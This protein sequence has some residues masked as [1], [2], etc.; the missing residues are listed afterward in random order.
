MAKIKKSKKKFQKTL[1]YLKT[2][3]RVLFLTTSNRWEGEKEKP[4]STQLAYEF[5]S[6]LPKKKV[7]ILEVPK[8]KIFPCEGNVS[9]SKGNRCGLREAVLNDK[10]KNPTGYH[11]CFAS[12]NNKDDEL[13][14]ISREIFRA[15]TV[16]FFASVRW[17]QANS[18]YQKLI[19]RLTWIENRHS[20]LDEKNVVAKIV[21]GFICVGQNWNGKKVVKT[22]KQVLKYFG[23]RVPK[24]LSW[25]WQYEK[26][27][28]DES[29]DAYKKGVVEFSKTF[30][31]R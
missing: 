7:K 5:A 1:A 22:Q 27:A 24:E 14:K 18:V 29:D 9:T 8:M 11:R 30:S 2:K 3:K 13:W 17:G 6:Q 4:K 23:F 12:L 31:L 10:K 21:A 19:E 25:N 28:D 20:T 26:N 15:D 16:V